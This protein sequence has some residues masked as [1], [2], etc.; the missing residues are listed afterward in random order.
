M[1]SGE[2]DR[3]AEHQQWEDHQ[4]AESDLCGFGRG[5]PDVRHGVRAAG[6]ED[7]AEHPAGQTNRDVL[8]D[9]PDERGQPRQEDPAAPDRDHRGGKGT[10]LSEHRPDHRNQRGGHQTLP[11]PRNPRR[12]GQQG[13]TDPRLRR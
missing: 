9:V 11:A 8:S 2:N 6:A 13:G 12:V 10:G 7:P 1:H 4:F 5:R 3:S